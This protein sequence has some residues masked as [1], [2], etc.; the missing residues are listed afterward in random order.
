MRVSGPATAQPARPYES[1]VYGGKRMV[2]STSG[3]INGHERLMVIYGG[4]VAVV[5]NLPFQYPSMLISYFLLS[6]SLQDC[7]GLHKIRPS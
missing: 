3:A 2:L 1:V 5:S 4:I 6:C 7:I